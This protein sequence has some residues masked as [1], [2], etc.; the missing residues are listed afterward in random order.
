MI[1]SC[2]IAAYCAADVVTVIL[3]NEMLQLF[4]SK[5]FKDMPKLLL[6]RTAELRTHPL[7][8]GIGRMQSEMVS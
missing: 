8:V 3:L 5:I 7:G 4:R 6:P 2:R 1:A